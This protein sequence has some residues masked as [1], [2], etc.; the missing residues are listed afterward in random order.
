MIYLGIK[1]RGG[2]KISQ[3][4]CQWEMYRESNDRLMGNENLM[5]LKKQSENTS[6][7]YQRT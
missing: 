2:K 1:S 7:V 4:L 6:E 5:D 3:S